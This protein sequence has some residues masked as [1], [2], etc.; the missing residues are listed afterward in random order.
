MKVI[1]LKFIDSH[2][3]PPN[4]TMNSSTYEDILR[5]KPFGWVYDDSQTFESFQFERI[6]PF[7]WHKVIDDNWKLSYYAIFLYI[8]TI[9]GLREYMRNRPAF[10]L[11]GPLFVWNLSLGI[12]SV[13]G[14]ARI[15]PGFIHTLSQPNGLYNSICLK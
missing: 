12:F 14:F 15:A 6:D 2:F 5:Q 7:Y 3:P 9:F 10:E 13:M 11:K 8:I 4:S 1:T